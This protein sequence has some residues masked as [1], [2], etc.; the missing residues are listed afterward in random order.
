MGPMAIPDYAPMLATRW[1]RL[2]TDP[3]WVYELKWDGVRTIATFD[4][5]STRLRSRAGNDSTSRYPEVARFGADRPLVLDGE[6]VAFDTRGRPS[7]EA[8]QQRMNLG[9]PAAVAT[10]MVDVPVAYVVFDVLY[11]GGDITAQPWERRRRRLE[12]LAL[13]ESLIP[14]SYVDGD[15]GPLWKLVE[16]RDLEGVV[17]KRRDSPYRPGLRSADWRKISRFLQVRGV[18]GGWLPGEGGRSDSFG[19]LLVGMWTEEGL[20]WAGAVGTGFD[21]VALAAIRG[22]LDEMAVPASPFLAD[23]QMPRNARF[24]EPR[25]VAMIRYKELTAAGKLRAPSFLGFTDDPPESVM[26]QAELG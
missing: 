25:L 26:W 18:V 15:P 11:D 4:G 10:A 24:V 9:S 8:I 20:R 13:T 3:G 7:F 1:E 2:F 21:H 6:I 17:A 23:A 14:A 12:G 5:T 22:A 16:Q 19:S